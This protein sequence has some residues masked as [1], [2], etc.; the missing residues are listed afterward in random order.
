MPF[1]NY[2]KTP[3]SGEHEGCQLLMLMMERTPGSGGNYGYFQQMMKW[4]PGSGGSKQWFWHVM[5]KKNIWEGFDKWWKVNLS[6][7][8]IK[9]AFNWWKKHIDWTCSRSG[10]QAEKMNVWNLML[11]TLG[12]LNFQNRVQLPS[13][14]ESVKPVIVSSI[15]GLWLWEKIVTSQLPF[16]YIVHNDV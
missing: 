7:V 15:S 6:M 8:V 13:N 4:T 1:T 10:P 12:P 2:G 14:T 16:M 9:D 5:K 3:G 11:G